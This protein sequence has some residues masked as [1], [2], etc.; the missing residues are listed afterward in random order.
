MLQSEQENFQARTLDPT[1]YGRFC[2]IETP[3]GTEIGL[4]KNLAIL[5]RVST[6]VNMDES[7]FIKELEREGLS[8]EETSGT[9]VFFNGVFIGNVKNEKEFVRNIKEKRRAGKSD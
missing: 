1:H 3:E 4:R 2:P 8:V 5:S 6:R 7:A 9:E